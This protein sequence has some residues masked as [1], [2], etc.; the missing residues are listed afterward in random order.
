MLGNIPHWILALLVVLLI[1]WNTVDL[2]RR[3]ERRTPS[4]L[5][6]YGGL[7]FAGLLLVCAAIP[8]LYHWRTITAIAS[9]TLAGAILLYAVIFAI[10]HLK[11]KQYD[12]HCL[13][14]SGLHLLLIVILVLRANGINIA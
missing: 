8:A 9:Y 10:C 2:I 5:L 11:K 6:S 14:Y 13:L 3:K 7:L 4:G 12:L 1:I